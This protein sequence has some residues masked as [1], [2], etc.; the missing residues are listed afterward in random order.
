MRKMTVAALAA[1]ALLL[2]A[3]CSARA[4]APT[5][6]SPATPTVLGTS[7]TATASGTASA[8]SSPTLLPSEGTTDPLTAEKLPS[9]HAQ[10]VVVTSGPTK[11]S[12]D[13]AIKL[14][15]NVLYYPGAKSVAVYHVLLTDSETRLLQPKSS[16]DKPLSVWMVSFH[17]VQTGPPTGTPGANATTAPTTGESANATIFLRAD[18]GYIIEWTQYPAAQ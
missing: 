15:S 12:Q 9:N 2:A 7:R 16:R 13:Q 14:A 18:T 3:G 17:G 4:V 1:F 5:A 10:K 8:P 11:I 6:Q